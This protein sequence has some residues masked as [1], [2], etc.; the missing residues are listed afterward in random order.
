M[1][2]LIQVQPAADL[3][4]CTPSQTPP[5]PW[6]Q[7]NDDSNHHHYHQDHKRIPP[8]DLHEYTHISDVDVEPNA[9]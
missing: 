2:N 6:K 5:K 4:V 7:Q 8:H 9:I 1:K 3:F